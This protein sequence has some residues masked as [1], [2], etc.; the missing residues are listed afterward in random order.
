MSKSQHGKHPSESAVTKT[1][2][3]LPVHTNAL[4]T[5]FGGTV[6]SWIDI[7]AAIAAERHARSIVVTA[8]ID[9]LH[10]IS[11]LRLGDIA[12]IQAQV[13]FTNKT[14]MEVG[15]RVDAENPLT[16]ETQHCVTAYT[17]FVSLNKNGKP[18]PVIPLLPVSDLEKKR[19]EEA[20]H[21]RESRNQ[22]R[23]MLSKKHT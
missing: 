10:F 23:K 13:N 12:L 2:I 16:G 18:T 8:S 20:K 11:P 3:V 4:G 15:V 21:R 19:F 7:A 22:L 17:T 6:M 14:S 1:E 5:I 9:A